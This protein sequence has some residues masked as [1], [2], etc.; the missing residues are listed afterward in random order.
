MGNAR[1]NF[2]RRVMHV[3]LFLGAIIGVVGLLFQIQHWP[4]VHELLIGAHAFTLIFW[5]CAIAELFIINTLPSKTKMVWIFIIAPLPILS[6]LFYHPLLY[7]LIEWGYLK[8]SK[9]KLFP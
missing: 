7:L 4:M 8:V 6:I 5:L 9:R 2:V 1:L 3:C